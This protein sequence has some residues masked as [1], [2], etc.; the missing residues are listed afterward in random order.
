MREAA[1]SYLRR[2]TC[3]Q[4]AALRGWGNMGTA[5]EEWG[6]LGMSDQEWVE[7]RPPAMYT[8]R[9]ED[10]YLADYPACSRIPACV[11]P[12]RGFSHCRLNQGC[13]P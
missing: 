7:L 1:R 4:W 12:E 10:E 13:H 11:D 6:R 5:G 2:F 3:P 8:D 9:G